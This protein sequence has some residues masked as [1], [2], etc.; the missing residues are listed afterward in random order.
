MM[1]HIF[2]AII[3]FAANLVSQSLSDYP[4]KIHVTHPDQATAA[5][6]LADKAADMLNKLSQV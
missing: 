3:F 4:T 1:K 5:H 6:F 2:V